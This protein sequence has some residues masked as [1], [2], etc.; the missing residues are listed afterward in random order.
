MIFKYYPAL[1][2]ILLILSSCNKKSEKEQPL[3]KPN[4]LW[5]TFEDASP[6][7][8]S[9]YGNTNFKTPTVDSL[10]LKG[11]QYVNA[12]S[13][14]PH[15]SAARSTLICGCY[16]TTSVTDVHREEYDTPSDI[17]YTEYLRKAGYFLANNDKTDYNTTLNH[18]D[19]WDE[20]GPNASYW[21]EKKKPKPT[22]FCCV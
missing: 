17:F 10:A 2:L 13:T 5:I 3:E 6:Y 20:S 11:I 16:A 8:F 7:G 4:F 1:L 19:L 18:K 15:C 22:F 21:S 9:A 12:S 14:A